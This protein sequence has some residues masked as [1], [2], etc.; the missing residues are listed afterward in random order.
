MQHPSLP[1]APVKSARKQMVDASMNAFEALE[2]SL[3][4]QTRA[5]QHPVALEQHQQQQQ[6]GAGEAAAAVAGE[7]SSQ[8]PVLQVEQAGSLRF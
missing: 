8:P 7:K 1:L 6:Q 4:T 3:A 2:R 5:V